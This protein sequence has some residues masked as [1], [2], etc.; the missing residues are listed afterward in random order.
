MKMN[1]K[2]IEQMFIK[3]FKKN[4]SA[5]HRRV[6]T[7]SY[8][9]EITTPELS[10]FQRFLDEGIA[11]CPKDIRDT[12]LPLDIDKANRVLREA[13]EFLFSINVEEEKNNLDGNYNGSIHIANNKLGIEPIKVNFSLNERVKSHDCSNYIIELPSFEFNHSTSDSPKDFYF[14]RKSKIGHFVGSIKII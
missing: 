2:E 12:D 11:F 6:T 5:L 7:Y 9:I 3:E 10:I 1:L 4:T 13:I 8:G 14:K